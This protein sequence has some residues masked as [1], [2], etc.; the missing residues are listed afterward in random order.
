MVVAT[1]ADDVALDWLRANFGGIVPLPD[2][3]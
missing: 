3:Q 2:W 1:D